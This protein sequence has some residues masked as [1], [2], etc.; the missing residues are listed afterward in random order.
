MSPVELNEINKKITAIKVRL[1]ELNRDTQ[2]F[3]ALSQN[4]KRA[5]ASVKMMELGVCDL[6]TFDLAEIQA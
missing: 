1:E 3:P 2:E 6:I 5:L 4:T